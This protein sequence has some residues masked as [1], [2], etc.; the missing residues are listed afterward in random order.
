MEQCFK[1]ENI[2]IEPLGNSAAAALFMKGYA[3]EEISK[4]VDLDKNDEIYPLIIG[5]KATK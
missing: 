5:I 2:V 1:K 3:F 4:E